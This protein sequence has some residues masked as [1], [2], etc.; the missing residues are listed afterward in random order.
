[1][2]GVITLIPIHPFTSRVVSLCEQDLESASKH[3]SVTPTIPN[4]LHFRHRRYLVTE[5]FFT[6]KV[7]G[8]ASKIRMI[9]QIIIIRKTIIPILKQ[10]FK[11]HQ[12]SY[13]VTGKPITSTIYDH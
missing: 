2:S 6:G 7:T 8:Y 11:F 3:L 5:I 10:Q 13:L 9:S 12:I 4:K 1:M